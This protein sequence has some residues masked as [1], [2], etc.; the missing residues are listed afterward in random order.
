MAEPVDDLNV[1]HGILVRGGKKKLM[2]L[3]SFL[4]TNV[5]DLKNYYEIARE[6]M[7]GAY[8][9]ESENADLELGLR[10]LK[11]DVDKLLDTLNDIS[12]YR[13]EI[14]HIL[15][16]YTEQEARYRTLRLLNK[17]AILRHRKR[18]ELS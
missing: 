5:I 3:C 9:S 7:D 2:K 16:M 1:D 12:G 13:D 8:Y 10:L 6:R 17:G 14:K 18:N 11:D 15:N 4:R